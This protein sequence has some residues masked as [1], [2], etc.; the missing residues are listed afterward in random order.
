MMVTKNHLSAALA[1]RGTARV[2]V[3]PAVIRLR[4]HEAGAA[5]RTMLAFV[6]MLA[7]AGCAATP[8]SDAAVRPTQT[9]RRVRDPDW[10]SS[11]RPD[12]DGRAR[13]HAGRPDRSG[14][15]LRGDAR[16]D[17]RPQPATSGSARNNRPRWRRCNRTTVAGGIALAMTECEVGKRAGLPGNVEIGSEAGGERTAALTYRQGPWPGIYR[18][19][20]GRLVSIERVE[21]IERPSRRRPPSREPAAKPTCAIPTRNDFCCSFRPRRCRFQLSVAA[22]YSPLAASHSSSARASASAAIAARLRKLARPWP[23]RARTDPGP[24]A[25]HRASRDRR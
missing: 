13:G 25:R 19:R 17:G 18:F 15:L 7:L 10:R 14:W 24:T 3:R 4:N 23:D 16:C 12:Q 11:R 22:S 5:A 9:A 21:V 1:V 20:G 8:G 6:A 2:F